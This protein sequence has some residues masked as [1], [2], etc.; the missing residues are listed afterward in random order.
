M[1]KT[2]DGVDRLSELISA[3]EYAALADQMPVHVREMLY[4]VLELDSWITRGGWL[5]QEWQDSQND[6]RDAALARLAD[7]L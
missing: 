7:R 6:A 5:P 2:Y 3:M 1:S 4:A